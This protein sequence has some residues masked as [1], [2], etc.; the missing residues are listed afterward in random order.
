MRQFRHWRA[1]RAASLLER[2]QWMRAPA[3]WACRSTLARAAASLDK[4]MTEN[5]V[6]SSR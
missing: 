4:T 3:D 5:M 2:A 6:A 1:R